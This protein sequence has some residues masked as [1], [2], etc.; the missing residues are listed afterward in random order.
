MYNSVG[1]GY[2]HVYTCM[3]LHACRGSHDP[4]HVL[5]GHVYVSTD[6]YMKKLM[7]MP[8]KPAIPGQRLIRGC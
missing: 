1:A 4:L 3:P 5:Q 2:A 8:D 7:L 6:L